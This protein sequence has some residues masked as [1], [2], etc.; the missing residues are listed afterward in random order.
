MLS[1]FFSYS[2]K[3]ETVRDELEVHLSQLKRE[4]TIS[5]W[6]DRRIEAGDDFAGVIN[7]NLEKA[8]I[9]LLLVSPYF[10][11]SDYCYEVEMQRA[12]KKHELGEVTVIPIILDPCDWKNAPFGKLLAVPRDG[13]PI[14]KYPN[15][16]DAF[17]EIVQAIRE[18]VKE[19]NFGD[20]KPQ[21]QIVKT[22][23]PEKI[24]SSN[25]SSN[26][27]IKKQFSDRDKDQFLEECFEFMANLFEGSLAELKTR[28]PEIET[29]FKRIDSN[30][31]TSTIYL[32]GSNASQARIWL[33]GRGSFSGDIAYS[34]NISGND[35]SYHESLQLMDD[36]HALFF[37]KAGMMSRYGNHSQDNLLT[38]QGAAEHFWSILI[39]PLQD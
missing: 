15:Q 26:L 3:D 31:F 25:R 13:K 8:N 9:I 20:A 32:K 37:R 6:H 24:I 7:K 18:I 27:R 2:H 1:I 28:N 17:L 33:A 22:S 11:A 14:S 39:Q 16:H 34:S 19:V 36:G 10:L 35:N 29:K 5:V 4:N 38:M 23:I 30:H 21:G 12:L